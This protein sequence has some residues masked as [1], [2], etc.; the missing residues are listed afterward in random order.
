MSQQNG[1]LDITF[2]AA[3]DLRLKQYHVVKSVGS[4]TPYAVQLVS[5]ETDVAYGILQN[6][7]NVGE[8][9]VVRV[10]GTSKL[11]RGGTAVTE[12]VQVT[13]DANGR[14]IPADADKEYIIGIALEPGATALDVFEVLIV[15][16]KASI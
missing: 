7:P 12:G 14:G 11:V 10:L 9:A 1:I 15:H 3:T 16:Y 8:A 2:P 5:A 13:T 6:K 4:A